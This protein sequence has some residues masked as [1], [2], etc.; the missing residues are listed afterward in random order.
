[1]DDW[2]SGSALKTMHEM[3][4]A[5]IQDLVGKALVGLVGQGYP[6]V[7][8]GK[9]LEKLAAG[10]F[11]ISKVLPTQA[12]WNVTLACDAVHG[13][14]SAAQILAQ[15]ALTTD[16]ARYLMTSGGALSTS[17]TVAVVFKSESPGAARAAIA[18]LDPGLPGVSIQSVTVT[19]FGSDGDDDA[20]IRAKMDA[21]FIGPDDF[22]TEDRLITWAKAAAPAPLLT[23]L[24]L[25]ADPV[26]P[27]GV[28]VTLANAGGPVAGGTVTAVQA[29]YDKL[30][31]I[32]DVNS[33]QNSTSHTIDA[34][35][36]VTVKTALAP[37][38]MAAADAAWAA[39]MSSAQIGA[40]VLLQTLREIVGLAIKSDPGSNFTGEAL[41]G[42]DPDGNV[43]LSSTEVPVAGDTLTNQLTWV[44][45]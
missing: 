25:D 34:S 28:I 8:T 33:A 10:W 21:R 7:A 14:F 30:S 15:A 29:A 41:A 43:T 39:N 16:G 4:S 17:S 22:S 20:A 13:P 24:R 31:P 32:G 5:I 42:S 36:T 35:G 11:G 40:R 26:F 19:D 18:A 37:R 2:E 45:T 44:L 1:L 6:D 3:E 9:S 23:R 38:A 12:I 27:G